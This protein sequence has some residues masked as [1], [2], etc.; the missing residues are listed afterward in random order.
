M[1]LYCLVPRLLSLDENLRAKDDGK[2]KTNETPVFTLPM[3]PCASSP[4]NRVLL[5]P[6]CET[7]HEKNE[8]PEEEAGTYRFYSR[9]LQSLTVVLP[10]AGPLNFR[11]LIGF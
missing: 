10:R 1:Y 2:E 4:V 8:A 9:F 5:S 6:L 7:M 3:D 11:Q